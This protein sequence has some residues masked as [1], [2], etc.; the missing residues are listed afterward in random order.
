MFKRSFH[1]THLYLTKMLKSLDLF[2]SLANGDDDPND[3]I[4]QAVTLHIKS[5]DHSRSKV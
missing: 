5:L 1:S 4:E 3:V 2:L